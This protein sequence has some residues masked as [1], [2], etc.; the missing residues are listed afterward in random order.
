MCSEDVRCLSLGMLT[1]GFGVDGFE[2]I[3]EMPS[4]WAVVPD[5]VPLPQVHTAPRR[6]DFSTAQS[7]AV[8][9]QVGAFPPLFQEVLHHVELKPLCRYHPFPQL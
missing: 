7:F 4:S 6:K 3:L 2:G 8:K 1:R 9:Q 5:T